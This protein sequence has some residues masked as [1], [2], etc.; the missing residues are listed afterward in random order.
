M[1]LAGNLDTKWV[2]EQ[3]DIMYVRSFLNTHLIASSKVCGQVAP[4]SQTE[5]N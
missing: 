4:T 3:Y 2:P 1:D 5:T